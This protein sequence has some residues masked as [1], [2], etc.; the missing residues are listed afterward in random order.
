MTFPAVVDDPVEEK[1][2]LILR[3][4]F[5]GA[6]HKALEKEGWRVLLAENLD[7]FEALKRAYPKLRIVEE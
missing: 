5:H 7:E 6:R 1:G 3:G 4:E 2:M